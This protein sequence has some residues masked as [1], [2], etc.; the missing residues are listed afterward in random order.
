MS[1]GDH[2]KVEGRNCWW[3]FVAYVIPDRGDGYVEAVEL[4]AGKVRNG[5]LRCLD[6]GK[7][8]EVKSVK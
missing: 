1:E 3:R 8:R 6:A 4:K 7:V 2:F 5:A